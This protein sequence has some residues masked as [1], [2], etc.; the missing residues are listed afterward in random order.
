V[1]ASGAE[2]MSKTPFVIFGIFAAICVLVIPYFALAKEGDEE[3]ATVEVAE[4]DQGA[5]ELFAGSC[6]RCHTLAAAGTEGVVGPD[7]DALLVTSG[8]NAPEQYESIY[9]RVLT[10]ITCGIPGGQIGQMPR[11]ILTGEN[12]KDVAQFVA[13]YSGQIDKG[14]TVDTV[15]AEKPEPGPCQPAGSQ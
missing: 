5:K 9:P 3:A 15:T 11:G 4:Q 14:P 6:G 2:R 1:P 12:A 8:A 7:L 13:A 10:A